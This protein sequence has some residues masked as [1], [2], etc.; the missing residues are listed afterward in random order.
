MSIIA[1]KSL[2]T[3]DNKNIDSVYLNYFINNE[4]GFQ[5]SCLKEKNFFAIFNFCCNLMKEIEIDKKSKGVELMEK[6]IPYNE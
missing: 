6:L 5:G 3:S 2:E 4:G 1:S